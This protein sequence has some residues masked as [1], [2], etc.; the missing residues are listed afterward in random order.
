MPLVRKLWR[1]YY[2]AGCLDKKKMSWTSGV[3]GGRQILVSVLS[4]S[5]VDKCDRRFNWPSRLEHTP[6]TPALRV[7]A[8]RTQTMTLGVCGEYGYWGIGAYGA[9]R[10]HWVMGK[11]EIYFRILRNVNLILKPLGR[12]LR[13]VPVLAKICMMTMM[14]TKTY[15]IDNFKIKRL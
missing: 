9:H 12:W 5:E 14:T 3:M 11:L 1:E 2:T 6:V 13:L 10:V 15:E 8:S 7:W 4:E